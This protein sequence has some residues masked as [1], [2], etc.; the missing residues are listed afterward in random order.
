[1]KILWGLETQNLITLSAK[2]SS[3]YHDMACSRKRVTKFKNQKTSPIVFSAFSL[4]DFP[5]GTRIMPYYA[6]VNRSFIDYLGRDRVQEEVQQIRAMQ[7]IA[8]QKCQG[9]AIFRCSSNRTRQVERSQRSCYTTD[10]GC[11]HRYVD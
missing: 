7:A 3:G 4:L 1:M 6:I 2:Q 5:T 9:K 10:L 11:R 8:E